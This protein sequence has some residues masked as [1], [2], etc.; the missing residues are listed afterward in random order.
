MTYLSFPSNFL[1]FLVALSSSPTSIGVL[2]PHNLSSEHPSFQ[3]CLPFLPHSFFY[4]C[5]VKSSSWNFFLCSNTPSICGQIH[6][7]CSISWNYSEQQYVLLYHITN[8][9][10]CYEIFHYIFFHKIY[11][12]KLCD[13][14]HYMNNNAHEKYFHTFA[15]VS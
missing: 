6:Y 1:S 14:N 13:H 5:Y 11:I 2:A 9:L 8:T 7:S 10:W 15:L 12:Q 3:I 4:P